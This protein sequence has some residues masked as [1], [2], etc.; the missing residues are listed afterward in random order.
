MVLTGMFGKRFLPVD[1]YNHQKDGVFI[2]AGPAFDA[3]ADLDSLSLVDVAPIVFGSMG[4]DVPE[5][6]TGAIPD[7]LLTA[8][9]GRAEYRDVAFGTGDDRGT[10]DGKTTERLKDLGYL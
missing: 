10:D 6:M 9:V 7:G 3:D 4:Y 5:R 2:G 8:P 1:V